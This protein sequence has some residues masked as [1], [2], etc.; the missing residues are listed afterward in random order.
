MVDQ[1][2]LEKHRADVPVSVTEQEYL[3]T[4]A[5]QGYEW[6]RG[7]LIKGSAGNLEHYDAVDYVR[8]LLRFYFVLNPMGRALGEPFL[9]RMTALQSNREPDIMVV[10][11]E[12]EG[13]LTDTAVI[14]A[15]DL[16][17]EIVSP[18][19]VKRD[20]RDK[21]IEYE[22]AGVIEYWIFDPIY[23]RASFNRRDES[24]VY[25]AQPLDD[26][27]SYRTPLLP[28]FVLHVPTLWQTPLPNI[29]EVSESIRKMVEAPQDTPKDSP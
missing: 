14:G 9:L 25:V 21:Y 5:E 20:Y 10:L 8:D 18:E 24:G 4:Y 2:Q 29:Y 23:K 17:I 11:N 26:Q 6:V 7:G 16:C 1:M 3:D 13:R 12:G 22:Q 27:G 19:S 15:A 28:K